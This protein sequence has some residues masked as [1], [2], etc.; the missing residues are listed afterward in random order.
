VLEE[1]D[2]IEEASL[3]LARE[4][5]HAE[6]RGIDLHIATSGDTHMRGD[7]EAVLRALRNLVANAIE[8]SSRDDTI[9]VA[10]DGRP[11]AICVTVDDAGPGVPLEVRDQIFDPFFRGPSAHGRRVGYGLGLAIVRDAAE[12]HGGSIAVAT[13]PAGG[14][15]FVLEL[16]RAT[17][18]INGR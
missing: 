11:G 4:R 17:N 9:D 15:R 10:I 13:S 18:S 2:L 7:R 8:W 1:F 16:P 3:R 5:N 14:A 6:Q 12:L